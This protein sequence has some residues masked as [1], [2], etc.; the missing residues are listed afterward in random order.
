MRIHHLNCVSTCPLGGRLMDGRSA[1]IV[2]R[3][4]LG[5]HCLLMET[6]SGLV[7]VVAGPGLR[8]DADPH[9]RLS[10][11]FLLLVKPDFRE[12]M[13]A[14]RQIQRLGFDPRDMRDIV[15]A[16]LD[17]DHAGGL[18]DFPHAR[19][20]LLDRECEHALQQ[21]S[22]LDRQRFGPQQWSSRAMAPLRA[23]GRGT[24]DG[25]RLR[26]QPRR[27]AAGAAAGIAARP[28]PR[29]RRGRN[30]PVHRLAPARRR[31]LLPCRRNGRRCAALPQGL[32]AYQWL[33]ELDCD[34]RL[35]NQDRL[36]Q[37]RRARSHDLAL[38]CSHDLA[39]FERLSGRSARLPAAAMQR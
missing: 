16:Y 28:Y 13:T 18:D 7:R 5:C 3:G 35:A 36:R 29:T 14:I 22:W 2:E 32:R 4:H 17:A 21:R 24:L 10:A 37:P 39:E 38:F 26:P 9:G 15:L 23:A 11:F 12:E 6:A 33:M 34:A 30:A 20:R 1:G 8:D 19:M 27:P 31:C 25:L